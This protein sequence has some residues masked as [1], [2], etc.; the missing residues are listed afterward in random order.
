MPDYKLTE[1]AKKDLREIS[2]HTKKTW[3]KGQEKAYREAIRA[4]LRVIAKTPKIGQK[5]DELTEGLRSFPVAHHIAYYLEKGD[6]I[7]VARILHPAMDREK[8][9]KK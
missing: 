7:E 3:G 2:A 1:A 9:M 4:A 6:G 8:A 5:R